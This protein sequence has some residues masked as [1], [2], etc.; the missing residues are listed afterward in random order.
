[1]WKRREIENYLMSPETLVRFAQ[2]SAKEAALG[3]IFEL[4]EMEKW[5]KLMQESI[6]D[7]IPRLAMQDRSSKWWVDTKATDDF[8]DPLMERFAKKLGVPNF[9]RKTDY[10]VLAPHVPKNQI[11]PE[12]SEVLDAIV[13]TEKEA[14]PAK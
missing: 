7:L 6:E 9:M 2:G 12:V 8:L 5:T 4:S 13:R 14:K 10:H 11:D 1:M 3:P